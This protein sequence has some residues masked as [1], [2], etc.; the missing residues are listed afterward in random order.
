MEKVS[1]Y[2]ERHHD[3]ANRTAVY[4]AVEGKRDYLI[5]SVDSLIA[6]GYATETVPGKKGTPI[7]STKPF[8]AEPSPPSPIV[9]NRPRD[10]GSQPSPPSHPPTGGTGDGTIIDDDYLEYLE[11]V[12]REMEEAGELA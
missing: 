4:A 11:G 7:R 2:L 1:R 8:R 10:D 12:A 9:P 6:D 5:V 3:G